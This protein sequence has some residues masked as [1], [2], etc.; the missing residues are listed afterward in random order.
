MLARSVLKRT[1]LRR[2]RLLKKTALREPFACTAP[3][4]Q[5]VEAERRV[6]GL[7]EPST[8]DF[9]PQTKPSVVVSR[10]LRDSARGERCTVCHPATCTHDPATVVLAHLP[11]DIAGYKSTDLS[12]CYAC[13]GNG[14]RIG[15]HNAIDAVGLVPEFDA[16]REWILRRAMV[17][18]L[19]RMVEKGL[20]IIRGAA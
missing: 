7:T 4:G 18:T 5:P 15:C 13:T 9:A 16:D 3:V 10:Q 14:D 19:T 12:S 2:K 1:P 20:I 6:A 17:L 8:A 11:C